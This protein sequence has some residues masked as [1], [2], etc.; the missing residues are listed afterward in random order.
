MNWLQGAQQMPSST[1]P[2]SGGSPT[3]EAPAVSQAPSAIP[4]PQARP[5]EAPQSQPDTSFFMRN[6]M[7]MR[8]PV[9]NDFLDPAGAQSVKG[10]DLIAKMMTYLHNKVA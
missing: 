8:D 2:P 1:L 6:A 5:A 3:P 4:L 10:P 7:Q 9:T